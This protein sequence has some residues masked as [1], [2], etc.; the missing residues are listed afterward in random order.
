M[1]LLLEHGADVERTATHDTLPPL[2]LACGSNTSVDIAQLLIN[3]GANVNGGEG[4][5]MT[6]LHWAAYEGNSEVLD[7]LIQSGADV[8][9]LSTDEDEDLPAGSTH[10]PSLCCCQR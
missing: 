9:I 8:N 7:L 10:S 3:A 4:R 5:T 1:S 2:I 6:P